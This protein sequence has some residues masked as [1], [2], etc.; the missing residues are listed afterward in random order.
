[1]SNTRFSKFTNQMQ[2]IRWAMAFLFTS[3]VAFV[4]SWGYMTQFPIVLNQ[5][6]ILQP[7]LLVNGFI[8]YQHIA[9]QKSPLLPQFIAWILP[10]FAH[11]AVQTARFTH[12]ALITLTLMICLLWTYKMGGG[13]ALIAS[14]AYVLAWSNLFGYWATA[15]YDVALGPFYFLLFILFTWKTKK[16]ALQIM[17]GGVIIG[18]AI[19]IKQYA[20]L[21]LF[22]GL[23]WLVWRM[24][25]EPFT[26]RTILALLAMYSV[27]VIFPLALYAIYY[28]SQAGSFNELIYWTLTFNLVSNYHSQGFLA[29]TFPQIKQMLPPF[30]LLIPFLSKIFRDQIE[31]SPSR[32]TRVWL[33]F[34]LAVSLSLLYPR[35][36]GRHWTTAFPFIAALSGLSCAELLKQR[37][38][39]QFSLYIAIVLWWSM[40]A[41]LIYFPQNN[42][43]PQSFV[44][45]SNLIELADLLEGRIPADGGLVL[46]PTHEDTSNLYYILKRPPPHFW[47]MNYPWFM[48]DYT[49][50]RWLATIEN[51]K[52][53]TLLFFKDKV[54][55]PQY[56]PEIWS[57]VQQNYHTIDTITWEA[58]IIDIMTRTR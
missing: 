12:V 17:A 15:Y 47:T 41:F 58:H 4:M 6:V 45:F 48:N 7:F 24:K 1:M 55:W 40:S 57:Y 53:Q 32:S 11:D 36:S 51:E 20:A 43:T 37:V 35:Y 18:I 5:R 16:I 27:G 19:L 56:G 54:D 30:L 39:G 50:S 2:S 21:L 25:S 49:N 13:W 33:C 3:V 46:L 31:L 34:F 22:V 29:P 9:D 10:F 28:Y 8:P 42:S 52:P 23:I 26:S 14:G 44:E 38:R